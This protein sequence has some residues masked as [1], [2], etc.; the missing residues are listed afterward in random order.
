MVKEHTLPPSLSLPLS[1]SHTLFLSLSEALTSLKGPKVL[2][3]IHTV[4]LF[5]GQINK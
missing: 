3:M 2:F 4:G 5:H 1:L